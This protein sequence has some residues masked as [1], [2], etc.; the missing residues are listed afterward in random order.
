ME[1]GLKVCCGILGNN[2]VVGYRGK[3]KRFVT[4]ASSRLPLVEAK[5]SFQKLR[6]VSFG[7]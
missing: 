6:K 1:K 2:Q 4:I 7:K 5:V 3:L